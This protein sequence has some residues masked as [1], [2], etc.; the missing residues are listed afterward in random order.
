MGNFSN[1]SK[2]PVVQKSSPVRRFGR[3]L[4]PVFLVATLVSF[5]APAMAQSGAVLST[6]SASGFA[7]AEVD[8]S[9]TLN[10]ATA[11]VSALQFDL[12][13]SG[14]LTHVSTATGAAATAAGKAVSAMDAA[15]GVRVLIFGM[16]QNAIGRG[17]VAVV[18]LS[19]GAAAPPGTIPLT[20]ANIV[21]SDGIGT[22]VSVTTDGGSVNVL[23]PQDTAAPVITAVSSSNISSSGATIRWTTNEPADTQVDYGPTASYGSSSPLDTAAVT[24]HSV[25]LSGLSPGTLYHYRARSRDAAGNMA[26]TGDFSFTTQ[27]A[28]DG[29]PAVISG[30]ASSDVTA[31]GAIISWATDEPSDTQVEYGTSTSYG[32]SSPPDRAMVTSHAASLTGLTPGVTYHYRVRS[33]D[34][35]GNIAYYGDM[36]FTTSQA[37]DD[38]R[39]PQ[40]ITVTATTIS[41]RGATILWTT[42]E[43][44]DGRV[45]YGLTTAYGFSSKLNTRPVTSHSQSLANLRSDTTYHFR[46][47]SRDAAGNS[48][49]SA[50]YTFKTSPSPRN[51]V[52]SF[53]PLLTGKSAP[54]ASVDVLE[55]T[56]IAVTNLSGV[57]A[58]ITFTAYDTA[59]NEISG[60]GIENPVELNLGPGMQMPVVDVELFGPGLMDKSSVG[61]IKVESTVPEITGFTL[62]FDSQLSTLDGGPAFAN[63]LNSFVLAEIEEQGFTDLHIVNP[64]D[65]SV[66]MDF[67]LISSDGAVLAASRREVQPN[68][69]LAETVA[70][71]FPGVPPQRSDYVKVCAT[72][73]VVPFELAGRRMHYLKG[74]SGLDAHAGS[75]RLFSPQYA[76]GGPWRTAL[77]IVNLDAQPD[78]L[79]LRMVGDDGVQ[80]GATRIVSIAGQGKVYIDDPSFFEAA[81]GHVSQG[82]VEIS[83]R[84]VRL[85]GSVSFADPENSRFAAALPLVSTPQGS[86][87]FSHV[88]SN[89]TYFTGLALL[90]TGARE[91]AASIELY[92]EDGTLAAVTTELIPARHRISRLLTQ[93]FPALL[94]E[95]WSSGYIR[96]TSDPG[97]IGFALF[98]THDLSALSAVPAQEVPR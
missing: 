80:I 47:I 1:C 9:V 40:L 49:T 24:S 86:M 19:I 59:G 17:A 58:T 88:A 82:C 14:A 78:L 12:Q 69:L 43:P 18:H 8:L 33:A 66:T 74:L 71:L 13:W 67:M 70:G 3:A 51:R 4:A 25:D 83:S 16:N 26:A 15:R 37:A 64:N 79:T 7:G 11:P 56:G 63:P 23:G 20:M 27:E 81:G 62:V 84:S 91:A 94:G 38:H 45:E 42:D 95:S 35:A 30:V 89:D 68:G 97:L 41:S 52:R 48:V 75:V 34:A 60:D 55:Y 2:N 22:P 72:R 87:V 28:R 53:Y 5:V 93:Y 85:A 31:T 21:A 44:S 39:P 50:D 46:V 10:P 32:N 54:N 96:V 61:W 65:A 6:G 76:A 36:S 73:G 92:R 57:E 90:N 29:R 98:G 77:S